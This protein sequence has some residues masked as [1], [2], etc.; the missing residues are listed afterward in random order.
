[1]G[2][3]TILSLLEQHQS[4]IIWTAV[5]TILGYS[6]WSMLYNLYFHPLAKFPGP[7]WAAISHGHEFYF[8]V[9]LYGRFFKQ[10][11]KMR[12]KYG[13]TLPFPQFHSKQQD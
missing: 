7:W 8:D 5:L 3:S 6:A 11:E 10:I 12:E 2:V 4:Y 1:M 9:I 13:T